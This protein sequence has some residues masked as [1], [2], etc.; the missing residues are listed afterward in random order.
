MFCGFKVEDSETPIRFE[1][2]DGKK[3]ATKCMPAIASLF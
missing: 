2:R 3:H 1:V